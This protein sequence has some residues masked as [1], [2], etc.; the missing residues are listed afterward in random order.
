MLTG[1]GCGGKGSNLHTRGL[2]GEFWH[3]QSKSEP[4]LKNPGENGSSGL[5]RQSEETPESI[6]GVSTAIPVVISGN[7]LSE[8]EIGGPVSSEDGGISA[9]VV[10]DDIDLMGLRLMLAIIP[11][12]PC[13][14]SHFHG[15]KR[16]I[17]GAS[18]GGG[19]HAS[20]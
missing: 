1:D 7:E 18:G 5:M 9:V 6:N 4:K 13:A 17:R 20:G 12:S 11:C 14:I 2:S 15:V 16:G 3:D 19:L 10:Y 8:S